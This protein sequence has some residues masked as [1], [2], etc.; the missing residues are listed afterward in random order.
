MVDED[1]AWQIL[2][3]AELVCSEADTAAAVR[4]MALEI[5]Q[6]LQHGMPLVLCVM[7]GGIVFAGQILPLL[8]FPL[9]VDY[10]HVTRYGGETHGGHVQ[11]KVQPR[12]PVSGRSVLVLDDVLDEGRT[13]AA[14]RERLLREGARE[15]LIAVFCEKDLGRAKP[16]RADFVGVL[17]PNR[18]LFGFG[19]D[20]NEAWRNLPAVYALKE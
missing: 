6:R 17:L 1:R 16:V 8:R 14:I 18:Y 10:V 5:T 13:L 20:V 12:T 3:E 15:V 19:M 11:W 2:R 4:R 7:G 9:Q